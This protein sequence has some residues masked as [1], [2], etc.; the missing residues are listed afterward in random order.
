MSADEFWHNGKWWKVEGDR[1]LDANSVSSFLL[2]C[3]KC[4]KSV[5]WDSQQLIP[6]DCDKSESVT[7]PPHYGGADDPYE[8]IKV[9]EAWEVS[10]CLGNV[11]KYIRRAGKKDGDRAM[12]LEKAR[13][14]LDREIANCRKAS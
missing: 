14:Y 1:F 12:D 11:L 9:I 13:F 10:F 4:G 5:A 3:P 7:H 2:H 6:C 8:A